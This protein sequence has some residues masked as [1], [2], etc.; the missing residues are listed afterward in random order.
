MPANPSAGSEFGWTFESGAAGDSAFN[1]LAEGETLELTYNIQVADD[2]GAINESP[3]D[4]S[5]VVVTITGT[6]DKPD[7]TVVDVTGDITEDSL[8]F[9][10][11]QGSIT[12]T[13]E[14]QAGQT[15]VFDWD[16]TFS[17]GEQIAWTHAGGEPVFGIIDSNI[18][19]DKSIGHLEESN[20]WLL[21]AVAFGGWV[22]GNANW[23]TLKGW[24]NNS[25]IQNLSLI[26][27]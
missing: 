19:S 22:G 21:R 6:N 4:T 1:F 23:A 20:K 10:L 8:G 12:E 3:T 7:I 9:S 17:P 2:S 24:D 18:V 11:H 16:Q 25:N 15:A 26:H 5:T 14:I 13:F 27:I